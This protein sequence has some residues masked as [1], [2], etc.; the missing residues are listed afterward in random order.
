MKL[1]IKAY[2]P[3]LIFWGESIF[4]DY[5]DYYNCD[6]LDNDA[7]RFIIN[8]QGVDLFDDYYE[9]IDYIWNSFKNK[10]LDISLPWIYN[11]SLYNRSFEEFKYTTNVLNMCGQ[12]SFLSSYFSDTSVV[13]INEFFDENGNIKESGLDERE[14][15]T[16]FNIIE[17][18][19]Q[20]NEDD[21]E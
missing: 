14:G 3:K 20:N 6:F 10:K 18:W 9:K 16:I 12:E 19:S 21:V 7:S 5:I 15:D 2:Q 13:D 11:S 17:R 4:E 8:M 1:Y